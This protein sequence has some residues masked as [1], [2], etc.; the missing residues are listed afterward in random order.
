MFSQDQSVIH[1]EV[2]FGA[3]KGLAMALGWQHDVAHAHRFQLCRHAGVMRS[4]ELRPRVFKESLRS[5]AMHSK[6]EFLPG[7]GDNSRAMHEALRANITVQYKSHDVKDA[8]SR[9]VCSSKA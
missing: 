6:A 7:Q 8:R 4:W 9:E 3:V 1:S 2:T 5:Q